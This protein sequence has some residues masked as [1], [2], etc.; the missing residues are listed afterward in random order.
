MVRALM[1]LL[2]LTVSALPLCQRP[3]AHSCCPSQTGHCATCVDQSPTLAS[4]R[5]AALP[6]PIPSPDTL[7]LPTP[8]PWNEPTLL[9]PA[10]LHA[11]SSP[12]R[13]LRI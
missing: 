9:T 11:R 3:V 5:T 7:P 6:T 13:P 2:A 1:L 10:S 8:A 4:A 12:A